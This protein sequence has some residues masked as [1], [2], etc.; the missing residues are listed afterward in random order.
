MIYVCAALLGFGAAIWQIG[1]VPLA[2]GPIAAPLV[3]VTLLAAWAGLRRPGE[4]WPALLTAGIALGVSSSE[5]TGWFLI[6]LLPA[7]LAGV[8]LIASSPARRLAMTPVIGG[9]AA[10]WYLALLAVVGGHPGLLTARPLD[11]LAAA[12][13]TAACTALA[14]LACWPLRVRSARLFP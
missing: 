7:A 3:P 14:A 8:L 10:A 1:V 12:L 11:V 13:W 9:A 4:T 5:R 6:A 2:F